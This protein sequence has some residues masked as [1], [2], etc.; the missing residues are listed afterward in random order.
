MLAALQL[1][2]KAY[3]QQ[4]ERLFLDTESEEIW[5]DPAEVEELLFEIHT[6]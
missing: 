6:Q 5:I 2:L 4:A 3:E 1:N